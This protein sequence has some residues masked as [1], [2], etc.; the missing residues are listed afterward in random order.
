MESRTV[1]VI[2][3]ICGLLMVA[4]PV[5]VVATNFSVYYSYAKAKLKLPP[6]K[7]VK[8]NIFSNALNTI[9][10]DEKPTNGKL[11]MHGGKVAPGE[12]VG[13]GTHGMEARA[14][15]PNG[16]ACLPPIYVPSCK[17]PPPDNPETFRKVR[18]AVE[19]MR[20]QGKIGQKK[21]DLAML[22]SVFASKGSWGS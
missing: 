11:K 16:S 4:L 8:Q 1:G 13:N 12:T 10:T 6:K 21:P 19:R 3:A 7:K 15:Q 22:V 18:N 9:A 5:S 14:N 17:L 20:E 2:C